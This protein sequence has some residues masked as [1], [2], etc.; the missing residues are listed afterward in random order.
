LARVLIVACGCRGLALAA[1]LGASGHAVRGTGRSPARALELEEAGVHGV[2][3][4]PD[5]LGT[6]LPAL[7]GVTAVCWLMGSAEDSPD[8][9][10][11]RLRSLMEHLVDTPVRGL[12]YESAGTVDVALLERG[13]SI[14]REASQTWH[15]PVEIVDTH[16]ASPEHWLEAMKAAVARLLLT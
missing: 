12:V 10:G 11:P 13:A 14:V 2:T 8:V 16:P 9:H 4:D 6:L 15:I 5:R 1:A 3:A 7:A